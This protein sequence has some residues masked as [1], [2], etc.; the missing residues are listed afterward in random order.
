[1]A[2]FKC[3]MCGG[4]LNIE[5]GATV[6]ECEFCGR[7]QTIPKLDDEKRANLY[8]RANHF[9]RTNDYD[10]AMGIYEIILNEDKTDAEAYW[11]ILLCKY[12]VEYVEDPATHKRVPTINRTQF[13]SILKD[14]DYK[15]ALKYADGYQR[16]IYEEEAK[17]IDK[18]QKGILAISGKEEPFDVFIC[19]KETD[20]SGRRTIDSVL[21]QDLYHNLKNEGLKVFFS[22]I[23]L[24]DKL[25]V[26]YE[27]YIFAGL[28]S[29]K[30]M[31]V[32]GSKLE[33]FNA[34]WVKNEWSRYLSLIRNGEKKTLI[35]AY[36]DMD[37]YDLPE[38]F[39]HLQA[40]DMNKL[41]FM[42]DLV[43]GI[44]K[45]IGRTTP[46]T[47]VKETV[48]VDNHHDTAPLLRRA[49]LFLED[50]DFDSANEYAE[51]VLDSNPECAEAYF[52]KLLAEL[53][54]HKPELLLQRE[55]AI[56]EYSNYKRAL[57]F[58]DKSFGAEL[59]NYNDKILENIENRRKEN[60]YQSA[61][62]KIELRLYEEAIEIFKTVIDYK[63]SESKI[64]ECN[65]LIET[66]RKEMVYNNAIARVSI[67][68]ASDVALK[69]SISE[70]QSISGY[71]NADGKVAELQARLE[72][73]YHDKRVA[74]EQAKIRAEEERLRKLREAELRKIKIEKRKQKLKKTAKIGVPSILALTLILVLTF[75]LFIPLGKYNKAN[76]LLNSGNY[77]EAIK[78]YEDLGGFSGSKAKIATINA[79]KTVENGSFEQGIKDALNAGAKVN[80]T[81]EF[82]GGNFVEGQSSEGVSP[83]SFTLY[84]EETPEAEKTYT[85]TKIE[86]FSRLIS[87]TRN[88][89]DFVKWDLVSCG[90]NVTS[91]SNTLNVRLIAIWSAKAYTISYDLNGGKVNGSNP[92]GYNPDDDTFTLINP[93]RTGYTFIGWTGT[94]LTDKTMQVT[95]ASG[96]YGNRSY[97]AYWQA[98]TYNITYDANG[99]IASKTQDTATYDSEFV[100]ATAERAGYTFLGW[101]IGNT[102]YEDF[103]CYN[104][105]N[106]LD[107]TAK[108]TYYTLSTST[109]NTRAG[110]YVVKTNDKITAG[111]SVTITAQ[112]NVGYKWK[113]WYSD[114][115]LKSKDLNY[116]FN[117]PKESINI[118]ATWEIISYTIS[119]NLDGGSDT[120]IDEYTVEDAVTITAPT[121]A[122]YTFDGWTGTDLSGKTM[123]VTIAKGSIGDRTYTANWTA[124]T[125][126]L[127]YD[128]NGGDALA[129][130]KQSVIYDASYSVVTPTRT[131]Y[132]F[133]KW[134]TSAGTVYSGGTWKTANSVTVIAEWKANTYTVNYNGNGGTPAKTSD[135]ATYDKMFTPITAS[136]TGYE[137]VCWKYNGEEFAGGKWDLTTSITLVAE[138]SPLNYIITYLGNEGTPSQLT[139][140]VTFDTSP[141]LA[142]ASRTGYIFKGWFNGA[143]EYVSGDVWKTANDIILTAEWEARTDTVYTV[144]HHQQNIYDDDYT[145]FETDNLKGK[146]DASITPTVKTYTGFTAPKTTTTTIAPDGSRIVDYY[147]TRNNYTITLI[148]N[149]GSGSAIVQKFESAIDKNTWSTR[150][151]YTFGGWFTDAT[152]TTEYTLT[153]MPAQNQTI[154][155]WWME[156]N[157][158]TDFTCSGTSTI[159]VSAYNG[160]STTMWIPDYIGGI[161]V[162]NISSS[163]FKDNTTLLKVIVPDSIVSVGL[164]AFEG[165]NSLNDMTLPFVGN[166][167]V[168]DSVSPYVDV[169]GYIFGFAITVDESTPNAVV[170]Y[171]TSLSA[172]HTTFYSYFI[173]KSLEKITITKQNQLPKSAF[174][175]CNFLLSVTLPATMTSI[176]AEAFAGCTMLPKVNMP[177]SLIEIGAG[178]FS[179]CSSLAKIEIPNIV[180]SIGNS[181]FYNCTLLTSIDIPNSVTNIGSYAFSDCI[182]LT[183]VTIGNSVTSIGDYAF[184]GC[185]ELTEI[186]FNA[187]N[188]ADFE[189]TNYVFTNVGTKEV[190]VTLNIGANVTRIPAYFTGG[191]SN[192]PTNKSYITSIGFED[193]SMCQSIGTMAFYYCDTLE[194]VKFG[195]N[196]QIASIGAEAFTN[197]YNL[198]TVDFENL[199]NLDSVGRRAFYDSGITSLTIPETVTYIGNMA[200]A[201]C[202][203][204][205]ELN[206]YAEKCVAAGP[207]ALSGEG[208]FYGS[209]NNVKLTIGAN[210]KNIE[211]VFS[212]NGYS[213]YEIEIASVHY[214]GTVDQW[215]QI[216]FNRHPLTKNLHIG[217]ELVED[218]VISSAVTKINDYA[219]CECTRLKSVVIESGVQEIGEFSFYGCSSLES[220]SMS[221][222]V[223]EIGS[224]AFSQCKKLNN[225][226][227][228]NGVKTIGEDAFQSCE[229]L[230]SITIPDS[231]T[232]IGD[233]AFAWCKALETVVVGDG[234]SILEHQLFVSC[235]NLKSIVIGSS[236]REISSGVFEK[237][238][239]L[240]TI[241]TQNGLPSK[242]Y[243]IDT[244]NAI[245][246]TAT[247]Y[248][249]SAQAPNLNLDS[250]AYDGNYWHY[251]DGIPTIWVYTPE[252]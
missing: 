237:C 81:Y 75:T 59:N 83:M 39:T 224:Y 71:K 116:T 37:P 147:Y 144:R 171:F 137:F 54:I 104:L 190:G 118:V 62:A 110:T 185:K 199:K 129:D 123:T 4:T 48:V 207:T 186:N 29:A 121:R 34:V 28:T 57:R 56:S 97:S 61:C 246:K 181:A 78:I 73:Y 19:Y 166:D 24:E 69:Q 219:F 133:V 38:E 35:P 86:D 142:T 125:Y 94:D 107:L 213:Q 100:L 148:A 132:S 183:S 108:W 150:D 23:T 91:D 17:E 227:I 49:Y 68:N 5:N 103:D 182:A 179:F 3:K 223:V 159:T 169:F 26:A 80:L 36:K 95:I 120:N 205:V 45:I 27:P 187:I 9:R 242:I 212:I 184:Y 72:K 114:G 79:V 2:V 10:K 124:N 42:Q 102:K 112:T 128:V 134:A 11:S 151:G 92:I 70:L 74:E 220:V 176:G 63:D 194:T 215:C 93:T 119:Y 249:F 234:I 221:E 200:F 228:P 210:V 193:N 50:G 241:F 158:P 126:T 109:N 77:E 101:Y 76:D 208:I 115:I 30:V 127:T 131:G 222:G 7:K 149:G 245:L 6:A 226:T 167:A 231:V 16:D 138:W 82:A 225:L 211:N 84:T 21:A 161:P 130:N 165:C 173:P 87:P 85:Y 232:E 106:G 139:Q 58:A 233:A 230:T 197:C 135:S 160:D 239:Q 156:E 136:R 65:D 90:V 170:Q 141:T 196:N 98:N 31:V 198:T 240:T 153:E 145:V 201:Y 43:Y 99:G 252:E 217:G 143:K 14:V 33:Y 67:S 47:V 13:T 244:D 41:G 203:D 15:N 214:L 178:A 51:K 162:T 146:S 8:D 174:R 192:T 44:K 1:M 40:Q 105:V 243:N 188:Y 111:E 88:G 216:N 206:Y 175:N 189:S 248:V 53:G 52:I 218:I 46:K 12:G 113:G 140:T 202:N 191:Y 32:I 250:T 209:G 64:E 18:I 229:S 152:L 22:R 25:G 195:K 60:V 238:N 20:H 117:M 89:Y 247:V 204:L 172:A 163:A 96:S 177:S 236:V 251:V 164:G 122:G 155:A 157:K 180:T 235:T 55:N 168:V 154:Y 66:E